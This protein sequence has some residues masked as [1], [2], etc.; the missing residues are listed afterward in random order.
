M[1]IY[2]TTVAVLFFFGS[3]MAQL[4]V[5]D[6]SYRQTPKHKW[7][8]GLH[9][10]HFITTGD[11][12][13]QSGF[14]TGIH[15]RRAL[16]YVFSLR[17]EGYYGEMSGVRFN[18]ENKFETNLWAASMHGV[19]SVNSLK[20]DDQVRRSNL[21]IYIGGGLNGFDVDH[22]NNGGA[23]GKNVENALS[24]ALDVGV[25]F[26]I[27]LNE[28][29]NVGVDHQITALFSQYADQVDG[30]QN[31]GFNDIMHYTSIRLNF[32]IGKKSKAEPLYWLNPL[33]QLLNEIGVLKDQKPFVPKDDDGDGVLNE[34]DLEPNTPLGVQVDTRG[35]TL[36]SDRDGI[37]NHKDKEPYSPPDFEYDE[38]G[39]AIRPLYVTQEQVDSTI[40]AQLERNRLLPW[41][42][43]N[44]HFKPDQYTIKETEMRKL[45]HVAKI[46]QLYDDLRLTVIG[47]A[48]RVGSEEDNDLLSYN[49]T[50]TVIDYLV[51][52]FGI[53]RDRF[54]LNWK[55][56]EDA[57]V[58]DLADSYM[59]RRVEFRVAKEDEVDMEKP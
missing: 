32:N 25:G 58:V 59:N 18:D 45:E 29:I 2:I 9:L 11:I 35:I 53:D 7:E 40:S 23:G 26:T 46:V 28:N 12:P 8:V 55:G 33:G 52:N 34:L 56:E 21:Y 22:Q 57:L 5:K 38:N 50:K 44:I 39:V 27:R 1:K 43:P 20:W 54:I 3:L 36:D 15:A 47:Y 48:D 10:G 37:P 49:R 4:D 42:L 13:F 41:F 17:F 30:F 14:A 51:N 19:I 16:D 31:D 6:V 24:P